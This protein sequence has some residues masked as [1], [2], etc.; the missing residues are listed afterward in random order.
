MM[1]MIIMRHSGPL[2]HSV[3]QLLKSK[4]QYMAT[5][6]LHAQHIPFESHPLSPGLLTGHP[7]K[8]GLCRIV[9]PEIENLWLFLGSKYI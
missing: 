8:D 4:W 6:Q 7:R 2:L 3:R 9:G 5:L 1:F